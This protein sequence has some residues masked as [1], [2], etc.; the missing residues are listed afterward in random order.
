MDHHHRHLLQKL[1]IVFLFL[2]NF[3]IFVNCWITLECTVPRNLQHA[4]EKCNI[5]PPTASDSHQNQQQQQQQFNNSNQSGITIHSNEPHNITSIIIQQIPMGKIPDLLLQNFTKLSQLTMEDCNVTTLENLGSSETLRVLHLDRN[6]LTEI[7]ETHLAGLTKLAEFKATDNQIESLHYA[8]FSNNT[9]LSEIDLSRNRI[10][11]L[12]PG[13]FKGSSYFT[14]VLARNM[15]TDIRLCFQNLE[16]LSTLDLSNNQIT[17]IPEDTFAQTTNLVDVYLQNNR[18]EILANNVFD[19]CSK[20]HSVDLSNNHLKSFTFNI[21]S[22][23]FTSFNIAYN[24]LTEFAVLTRQPNLTDLHVFAQNNS[25]STF[26]VQEPIPLVELN[27]CYNRVTSLTSIVKLNALKS[28][29]LCGNNLANSDLESFRNLKNMAE[30]DMSNTSI[31]KECLPIFISLPNINRYLDLSWNPAVAQYDWN[32]PSVS[33]LTVLRLNGCNLTT[34]D[35]QA[36]K[37]TFPNLVELEIFH[38]RFQCTDL[39]NILK[40]ISVQGIEYKKTDKSGDGYVD[41]IRCLNE[42][43]ITKLDLVPRYNTEATTEED[44]L[45]N[46]QNDQP[47]TT[48]SESSTTIYSTAAINTDT[49]TDIATTAKQLENK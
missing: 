12:T 32:Q 17:Q 26:F 5:E 10:G 33:P 44:E 20:L 22:S 34:L 11:G 4:R 3:L 27:L 1:M 14:I 16:N 28:L 18:I 39:V 19:E 6:E 43:K 2:S 41:G 47:T 15:I 42:T 48:N 31:G 7:D 46:M 25:V 23:Q 37:Q 8:A 36:L 29:Q 35:A 13:V 45:F 24:D 49:T 21:P 9:L 40:A 38:N 30:L